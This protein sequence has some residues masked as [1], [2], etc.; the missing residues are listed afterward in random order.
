MKNIL[1]ILSGAL[2][3]FASGCE[4]HAVVEA[5]KKE[6]STTKR[7]AN[8]GALV[9]RIHSEDKFLGEAR[10]EFHWTGK[11]RGGY[12]PEDVGEEEIKVIFDRDGQSAQLQVTHPEYH[13]FRR[14]VIFKKGR[15]I[16][17]DDIVLERVTADTAATVTGKVY[18]EDD[19]NPEDIRVW[20]GSRCTT[21]TNEKGDFVLTGL[22][23]GKITVSARK[24]GYY[25][26]RT[27]VFVSKGGTAACELNGYRTRKAKVRWVFQPDGS[28]NFA[29]DNIVSGTAIVQDGVQDRVSFSKG[30]KQVRRESDFFI[31]Q[32]NDKLVIRNFDS[33][34][35]ENRPVLMEVHSSFDDVTEA[36]D[37]GSRSHNLTLGAGK[38]YVF[39][40]YDGKHYAKM[41]ILEIID[42]LPE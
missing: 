1:I 41:E 38:V 8:H 37:F 22:R 28:K 21:R 5:T 32:K 34:G 31:Y 23:S 35:G 14:P 2:M 42:E 16:V 25:G 9:Y 15:V 33:R 36:G 13:E 20:G 39:R 4:M 19:A 10:T 11:G 26:L 18:L 27:T 24:P 12:R 7:Y 30:F 3:L 6:L 17:W 40:C 29:N